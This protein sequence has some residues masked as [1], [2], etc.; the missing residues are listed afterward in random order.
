LIARDQMRPAFLFD[1]VS[2]HRV[3][4]ESLRA[5]DP[6][7]QS[8]ANLNRPDDYFSALAAV[9]FACPDDVRERLGAHERS[10]PE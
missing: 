1:R 3:P 4:V 9:G 10:A 6:E 8:L 2:T 7:L 5:V